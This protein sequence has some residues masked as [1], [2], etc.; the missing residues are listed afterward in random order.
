MKH[1]LKVFSTL[2]LFS[3]MMVNVEAQTRTKVKQSKTKIKTK[4]EP[5]FVEQNFGSPSAI[6]DITDVADSNRSYNSVKSLVDNHVTVSY[7]DNTFRGNEPL[8]RGDFLV[9][10]N[11]ALDA[12]K[13]L[14][15]QNGIDSMMNA[16]NTNNTMTTM[17]TD[18]SISN[19][20]NANTGNMN[21]GMAVSDYSDLEEGSV[22]YPA[23]QALLEKGVTA[24]FPENSKKLNPG[25]TISE[26]EVYNVLNQVFGYDMTGMNPYATAIT[27]NKFAMVLNNAVTTKMQEEYAMID[28]KNAEAEQMK[29]QEKQKMA[30]EMQTQGQARKDSLNSAY[31]AE[32]QEIERKALEAQSK[33]KHKK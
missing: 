22:Y 20:P 31:Q 19:N 26:K 13:N 15:V 12:V 14:A 10:V 1:Y 11:S 4:A 30:A 29:Q 33:K 7:D 5:K 27:R 2:L 32:Q 3:F 17:A 18:N 8:R 28:Q 9:A 16:A 23:V 21:S 25:A 6:T 24:P